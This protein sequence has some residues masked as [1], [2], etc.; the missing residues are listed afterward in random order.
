M[1]WTREE[2][3]WNLIEPRQGWFEWAKFD[4]AVGILQ[5]HNIS[6]VGKLV[7]SAAWASSAPA[8]TAASVVGYYPPTNPANFA[9]YAKAVVHR[10]KGTVH[11]WEIWNEE[12]HPNLLAPRT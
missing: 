12:N 6:V 4:Q 9:A 3:D 8:G 1:R 10:Y 5:A 2:F 11:V 7:Y